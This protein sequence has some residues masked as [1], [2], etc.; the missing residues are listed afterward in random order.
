MELKNL[1]DWFETVKSQLYEELD[2]LSQILDEM[3][4]EMQ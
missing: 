1:R 2:E 4:K 3:D